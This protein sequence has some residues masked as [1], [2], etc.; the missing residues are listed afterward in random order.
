MWV[1][2]LSFTDYAAAGHTPQPLDGSL[3]LCLDGGGGIFYVLGQFLLHNEKDK[4]LH[5]E[6]LRMVFPRAHALPVSLTNC[7]YPRRLM[8]LF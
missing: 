2:N 5:S 3:F 4:M 7:V 8:F 6:R 1:V